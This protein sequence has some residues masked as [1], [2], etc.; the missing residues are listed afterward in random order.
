MNN[1]GIKSDI[2]TVWLNGCFDILHRGHIEMLKYAKSLGGRTI[3]GLD[4]DE[5]VKE[6]KGKNRPINTLE[7]RMELIRS[8]RDVDAVISFDSDEHLISILQEFRPKYRVIGGDYKNEN[9][10][11]EE[12]SGIIKYFDRIP[13]Y[14]TTGIINVR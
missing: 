3:V 13:N 10:V 6:L 12:H 11:G 9:I 7:D 8:L 1:T 4:T 14:S 5:R 2:Y